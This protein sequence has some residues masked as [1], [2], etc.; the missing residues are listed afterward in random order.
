MKTLIQNLGLTI[1]AFNEFFIVSSKNGGFVLK[2]Y[3]GFSEQYHIFELR[4]LLATFKSA[5]SI[6][7]LMHAVI[8]NSNSRYSH[9]NAL[10]TFNDRDP[11]G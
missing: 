5:K 1:T 4:N 6:E 9:S 2:I 3:H 7:F 10:V 11:L 8:R